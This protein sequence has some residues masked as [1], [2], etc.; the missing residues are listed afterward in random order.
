MTLSFHRLLSFPSLSSLLSHPLSIQCTTQQG[1]LV[2]SRCLPP[3]SSTHPLADSGKEPP[4]H[5]APVGSGSRRCPPEGPAH[6]LLTARVSWE[7]TRLTFD[8]VLAS[9]RLWKDQLTWMDELCP[10]YPL[11]SVC[12]ATDSKHC[13]LTEELQERGAACG[14]P[15][16]AGKKKQVQVMS[17]QEGCPPNPTW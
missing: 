15:T 7:I 12:P 10:H 14:T 2:T 5:T 17:W 16:S 8:L 6:Y 4:P 1:R 11:T 13:S 3:H 9:F